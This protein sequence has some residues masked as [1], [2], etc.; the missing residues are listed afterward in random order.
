MT[1]SRKFASKEPQSAIQKSECQ[2]KCLDARYLCFL[3]MNLL[4][5]TRTPVL[6]N[7][8]NTLK[9]HIPGGDKGTWRVCV[10]TEDGLCH[11]NATITYGPLPTC[12][13]L[14]PNN[15]WERYSREKQKSL[16]KNCFSQNL[17]TDFH[18]NKI[19]N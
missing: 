19:I 11:S 9:F 14:Q 2:Q 18:K 5:L 3:S 17:H 4:F 13:G 1:R 16:C 6:E 8:N 15:T 10:V 12:T 7:K